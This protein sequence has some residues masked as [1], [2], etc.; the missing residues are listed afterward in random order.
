MELSDA[1]RKRR[2]VRDFN[3]KNISNKDLNKI[4]D[5]ARWAPSSCNQQLWHFIIIKDKNIKK[6]LVNFAGSSSLIEKSPVTIAV[7][8]HNANIKEAIETGS[9]AAQNI[10][11]AATALG[12]GSLWLDSIGN[13]KKIKRIL[14]IPKEYMIVCFVMLGHPSKKIT[15]VPKRKELPKIV[16]TNRF[17]SV[18]RE[19]FFHDPDKWSL[20][21]IKDYQKYFCRKTELGTK[22]DTVGELEIR[23]LKKF[24]K[25]RPV[26]DL[27]PYDGSLLDNFSKTKINTLDLTQ[28][29]SEYT[30]NAT[31]RQIDRLI[32][33]NNKIPLKSN[34]IPYATCVFK[35][36]RLPEK[37]HFPLFKE[38]RRILKPDGKMIIIM[39]N[40]YS[41]YGLFYAL[42]RILF[43]DDIRKTGIY[44]FFGPY[45]PISPGKVKK[46]LKNTGFHVKVQKFFLIP[47]ISSDLYE[48]LLQYLSSKGSSFLHRKKRKTFLC[49]FIRWL[50]NIQGLR[51]N[52]FGSDSVLVGTVI[53]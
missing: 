41:L 17:L 7:C 47:A 42:L 35:L 12:I 22:M 16:S 2:S 25:N 48:L 10:L 44:S 21:E 53:K 27:F 29:S 4:L 6:D 18:K 8:Y 40:K 52:F 13:E 26:L 28:E 5:A 9:A 49:T 38:V 50:T 39:R 24:L 46:Q 45:K 11:L 19:K 43:K 32:Y 36:E 33:R 14:R 15:S 37:E 20:D 23:L 30:G 34:S 51:R 3:D 31:K 1:I